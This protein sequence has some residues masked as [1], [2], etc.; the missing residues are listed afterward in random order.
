MTRF[1]ARAALL[2]AA[3]LSSIALARPALARTAETA[4]FGVQAQ[5]LADA[6]VA[7]GARACEAPTIGQVAATTDAAD[8]DQ[9]DVAPREV[10]LQV[11]MSCAARAGD[12]PTAR[13]P[14]PPPAA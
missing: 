12:R 8:F 7:Q 6:A 9:L 14:R 1:A 4:A 13:P 10:L 11:R 2:A 3:G 5:Q